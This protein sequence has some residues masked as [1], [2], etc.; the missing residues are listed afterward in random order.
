MFGG[1]FGNVGNIE[2]Y[3]AGQLQGRAEV[4]MTLDIN[5]N[6]KVTRRRVHAPMDLWASGRTPSTRAKPANRRG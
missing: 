4:F 1:Q 5:Q 3:R 6:G 2:N